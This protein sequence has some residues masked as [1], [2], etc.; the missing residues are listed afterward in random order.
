MIVLAGV[1]L[2]TVSTQ[3]LHAEL[4]AALARIGMTVTSIGARALPGI[5]LTTVLALV[6]VLSATLG[7]GTLVLACR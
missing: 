2:R 6:A 4:P 7:P 1:T 3:E 5:G